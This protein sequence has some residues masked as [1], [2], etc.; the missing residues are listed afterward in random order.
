MT[1]LTVRAGRRE[2]GKIAR[3]SREKTRIPFRCNNI[4]HGDT[5]QINR[6]PVLF[7]WRRGFSRFACLTMSERS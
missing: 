7:L 5:A 2:I 6:C 1:A 3:A 4:F